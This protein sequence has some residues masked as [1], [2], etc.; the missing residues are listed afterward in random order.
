MKSWKKQDLVYE[1]RM[2]F[3]FTDDLKEVENIVNGTRDSPTVK[4][5]GFKKLKNKNKFKKW[6]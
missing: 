4:K 6:A 3:I 5:M 2:N 1:E